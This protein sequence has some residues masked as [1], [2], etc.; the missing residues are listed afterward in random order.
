MI[1]YE[2]SHS[3]QELITLQEAKQQLRVDT[4]VMHEDSLIQ[5]YIAEARE[6]AEDYLGKYIAERS[7]VIK[8]SDYIQNIE[9]HYAPIIAVQGVVVDTENG[10][11]VNLTADVDYSYDVVGRDVRVMNYKST[12]TDLVFNPDNPTSV[13]INCK[14]GYNTNN[15]PKSIISG[16]K[17][18]LTYLFENR[19]DRPQEK[20]MVA[21][22]ILRAHRKWY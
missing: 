5:S 13:T 11:V 4:I 15:C 6:I 16:M 14:V 3:V 9:Q 18:L 21:K 1:K 2:L 20:Q 10:D 22:N 12:A 17:L 8:S 7:L 19:E